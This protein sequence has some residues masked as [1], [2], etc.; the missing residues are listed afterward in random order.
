MCKFCLHRVLCVLLLPSASKDQRSHTATSIKICF[1]SLFFPPFLPPLPH[2]LF[3]FLLPIPLPPP[4]TP[5]PGEK[6]HIS[7]F[8]GCIQTIE[9]KRIS[10]NLPVTHHLTLRKSRWRNHSLESQ[11]F[12]ESA[13]GPGQ[14]TPCPQ[15]LYCGSAAWLQGKALWGVRVSDFWTPR[16]I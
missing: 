15:S 4:P 7:P 6:K 2:F 11:L 3:S 14:S 13:L 9:V 8:S 1:Y 16:P 10:R 5:T 12:M